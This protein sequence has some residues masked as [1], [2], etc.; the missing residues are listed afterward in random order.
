M[1]LESE[2]ETYEQ[3]RAEWIAAGQEN[4]WVVIHG[5]DVLGFFDTLDAAVEAG[6]Q[7]YGLTELFMVRQVSQQHAPIHASRRA[8]HAHHQ[9]DD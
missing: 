9:P 2:L 1:A 4:R 7:K 6:Y 8:V 3:R 5:A